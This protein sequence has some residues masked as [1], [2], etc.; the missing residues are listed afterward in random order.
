MDDLNVSVKLYLAH[1]GRRQNSLSLTTNF[2]QNITEPSKGISYLAFDLGK[3][4]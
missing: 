2:S 1:K 4:D 3:T